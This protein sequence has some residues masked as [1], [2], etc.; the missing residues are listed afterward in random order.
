MADNKRF[1]DVHG[2]FREKRPTV[3]R[4]TPDFLIN[5]LCRLLHEDEINNFIKK[6]GHLSEFEFIT[7][8]LEEFDVTLNVRGTDHIPA[9]GGC[10]IASNHPLG[11]LDALAL[12]HAVSEVRNDLRFI[13]NDVLLQLEN[14]KGIF[15]GVN[16]FGRNRNEVLNT[17]DELYASGKTILIFPAGLV[18]RKNKNGLIRDLEWKKS[19]VNKSR[20]YGLPVIPVHINGRNSDRFYNLARWRKSM[21]IRVNIEMMLLPDEMYRQKGKTIDI[22]FGEPWYPDEKFSHLN[23]YSVASMIREHVYELADRPSAQ[24]SEKI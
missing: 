6:N 11:G 19:F 17:I 18:S 22:I 4:F 10:V 21:G 20:K 14:L 1:I 13:V 8:V 15:T 2:I 24:L 3:Y 7:K 23:D 16:K 12:I 5:A 9:Q